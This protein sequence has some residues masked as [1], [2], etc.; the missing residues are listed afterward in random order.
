MA[1]QSKGQWEDFMSPRFFKALGDP[2]RVSILRLLAE[3]PEECT[4]SQL[5][6]MCS[7]GMS[8]VSRHLSVLR[9]AGI[10]DCERRGKEVYYRVRGDD[11]VSVLQQLTDYLR[12]RCTP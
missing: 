3:A 6:G 11:V 7:V 5:T 1:G 12:E 10:V 9:E 4:V 2:T 8:A